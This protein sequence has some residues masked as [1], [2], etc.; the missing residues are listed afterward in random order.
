V[1]G[2][3]APTQSLPTEAA[4]CHDLGV[5]RTTLREAMKRLHGKGLLA[6]G[7]RSGMRVLPMMHWNQLD[8]EVLAWRLEQGITPE[9]ADQLYEV[10]ACIEPRA[11]HLAARHG[12]AADHAAMRAAFDRLADDSLP[13]ELRVEADLR[14]HQAVFAATQNMF[15]A[16]LGVALG[17]VLKLS[18]MLSQSS[19]PMPGPE[20]DLHRAI[21]DAITG[22]H[23]LQAERTMRELLVAARGT[24]EIVL[25]ES[26][27]PAEE[28][29]A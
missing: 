29:T 16:S 7:P 2:H 1:G 25:H 23:A 5:S 24:L 26:K 21:C 27:Y 22:G 13:T 15:L 9:L 17:T 8:P 6:G 19:M 12:T 18:F 28:M 10:R 20:V 4:L 3:Y 14:F 11:C